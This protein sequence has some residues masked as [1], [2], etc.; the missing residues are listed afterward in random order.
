MRCSE[1]YEFTIESALAAVSKVEKR[2][3]MRVLL[4]LQKYLAPNLYWKFREL[5]FYLKI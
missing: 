2:N 1:A 5:K 3:S 4:L